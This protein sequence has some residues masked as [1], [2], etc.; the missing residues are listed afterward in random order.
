ML[1][2]PVGIGEPGE[3][4]RILVSVPH[5]NRPVVREIVKHAPGG[6]EHGGGRG[7]IDGVALE[8]GVEGFID[9]AWQVVAGRRVVTVLEGRGNAVGQVCGD[10]LSNVPLLFE[11]HAVG[12]GADVDVEQIRDRPLVLHV[13][14]GRKVGGEGGVERPR[15]FVGVDGEQVV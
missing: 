1:R 9:Q 10:E 3:G 11:E 2:R 12:V 14:S 5:T 13:P 15:T 8:L 6:L 7:W 4:K